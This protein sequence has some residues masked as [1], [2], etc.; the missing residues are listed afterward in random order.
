ME[1]DVDGLSVTDARGRWVLTAAILGS[2]IAFLDITVVNVALRD[3]GQALSGSLSG[4]QW[5]VNGYTLTLS[6]LLLIGGSLGDVLGRRRIFV[7]GLGAFAATSALC[8][9]A[10]SIGFLVAARA[11]QGAAGAMLVP[12]SL[13]L[14][15]ALFEPA[16]RGR[17]IG[18]W[19]GL[20]GVTTA[21]G[22]FV[23]GALVDNASW[24]WVFLLNIPLAAVAIAIAQTRVPE[25]RDP[26]P[27]RPDV[28]GAL[29]ISAGL[30]GITYALIEASARGFGDH[31]RRIAGAGGLVAVWVFTRVE[32]ARRDPMLPLELFRS[33]QFT[34][35]NLTTLAVY[36]A[37]GGTMFILVL[38]LRAQLDYS[39]T[40]AGLAVIPVTAL[41]LVLS[42]GAGALADR[43]GPRA[44]MTVGPLVAGAGMWLY[45]TVAPGDTYATSVLPASLV[46]GLGLSAT[47]APLTTAV[48]A[49][50]QQRHSGITSAV[51]NAA[52]RVAGLL[53]VA[54]L[55]I[56]VG[57][58]GTAQAVLTLGQFQRAMWITA[59]V[60]AAGGL[61]A[62]ATVRSSAD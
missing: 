19:S 34:G 21:I 10:P 39:G 2:G 14:I 55:P 49:A 37:L 24:R 26:N 16:Q 5:V 28:S 15:A 40:E 48:L 62:W 18:R 4:L 13:S 12:G 36:A 17:A 53:A 22:P 51:N 11:L 6:S 58:S 8:A 35:A 29:A 3:I 27:R 30:A 59:G 9:A 56:A 50:V 7:L 57:A 42:P 31:D 32:R 23:G 38:H 1:R 20:A 43:I 41:L 25:S 33:R 45:S 54:L 61:V 60:C 44:P 52:A 46:F 47:V